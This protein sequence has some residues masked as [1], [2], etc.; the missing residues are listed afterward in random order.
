MNFLKTFLAA[1]LAFVAANMLL[2]ILTIMF[3]ASMAAFSGGSQA[4]AVAKNTVLH[5]DLGGGLTDSPEQSPFKLTGFLGNNLEFNRSN[6][7]LQALS[8]IERATDDNKIKGIY[9]NLKGG[10]SISNLEE[11]RTAIQRF[12][13]ESGKFV[14]AYSEQYSHGSYY[15]ASV[16][17]AVYINPQGDMAWAGLSA[18]VM[19]YKGLLDKLGVEMQILRHGTFKSAVEPFMLDRMSPAN[20]LQ[21]DVLLNTIW[22]SMLTDISE[23]RGI[24][25]AQLSQ[26]AT[27]LSLVKKGSDAVRCGLADAVAYE[28]QVRSL[29]SQLATGKMSLEDIALPADDT[30]ENIDDPILMPL[31]DYIAAGYAVSPRPSKNKIAIVYADGGIVDG[32]SSDGSIGGETM[33]EKLARARKDK[34]V[35]AVVLRVNSPGGSALASELMWREIELIKRDKP[36]VVSMGSMAASGG[37]YISCPADVILSNRTTLTGSIGV[38][39][40]IPYYGKALEE[41]LGVT[42]DVVKTNPSADMGSIFRRLDDRERETVLSGVK[43]IYDVFVGHVADGRNMSYEQ[44]DNIGEGRVWSG[45]SALEIGLVDGWG[46]FKDAIALAADRAGISDDFRTWEV[47]EQED[48]VMAM[49]RAFGI[50]RSTNPLEGEFSE[51]MEHYNYIKSALTGPSVQARMPEVIEIR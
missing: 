9:I 24:D 50:V 31:S 25:T 34:N 29:L 23:S 18:N 13:E 3:F 36:V 48:N 49:L 45:A 22:G 11:L 42:V 2:F 44:V 41:K 8:A 17:D 30:D 47:L 26:Y 7:V 15:L 28:D 40:M 43:E 51:L 27:D 35:K 12:K 19:F 4:P 46:G 37:Y 33:V 39:G 5:I 6:T 20:R 10:T 14:I 32:P 1:F 16:A 38:F 21:Y